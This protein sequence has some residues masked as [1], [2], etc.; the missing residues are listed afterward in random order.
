MTNFFISSFKTA[1]MWVEQEPNSEDTR[2]RIRDGL[3]FFTQDCYR[4]GA[5]NTRGG[6]DNNVKIKCDEENN[7]QTMVDNG[8]LDCDYSFHPVE[9]VES[10]TI[11]IFQTRDGLN[12]SDN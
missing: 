9:A 10:A 2:R 3:R 1:F 4:N 6:Y 11:N 7:S 8:E 12:I 5:Y